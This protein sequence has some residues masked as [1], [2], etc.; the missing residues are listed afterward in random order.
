MGYIDAYN[1]IPDDSE[2]DSE[3]EWSEHEDELTARRRHKR[4]YIKPDEE[5]EPAGWWCNLL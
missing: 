3:S 5:Q 2:P 4:S 1:I